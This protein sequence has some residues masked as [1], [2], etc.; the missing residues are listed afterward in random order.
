MRSILIAISVLI[1][2]GSALADPAYRYRN[3][4]RHHSHQP[5]VLPWVA[6]AIGLGVLGALT[7][8]RPV[9]RCWNEYVGDD[10]RGR[11]VYER[12]CNF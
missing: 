4:P 12:I 9:R 5:N 3:V 6:G 1:M 7:Y 8:D 10:Y 11:P 2:T